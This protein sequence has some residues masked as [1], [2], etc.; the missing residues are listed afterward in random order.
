MYSVVIPLLENQNIEQKLFNMLSSVYE[1]NYVHDIKHTKYLY[2]KHFNENLL[3]NYEIIDLIG[4]GSIG[5]VYKIKEKE[6][7]KELVMKVKHHILNH[8]YYYSRDF[9]IIYKIKYFNKYFYNYFPFNLVD[10][11]GRFYKQSDF[12]NESNNLLYFYN[13]YKDNKYIIIPK[14]IKTSRDIIIMEHIEE[15]V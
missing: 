14:L 5:Q 6:T 4:S 2:K 12:I 10:F 11:L 13:N 7:N 3:D 9:K 1:D 8:K 15:N